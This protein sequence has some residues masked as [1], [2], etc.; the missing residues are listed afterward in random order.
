MRALTVNIRNAIQKSGKSATFIGLRGYTCKHGSVSNRTILGNYSYQ[1]AKDADIASLQA[2]TASELSRVIGYDIAL[3]EKAMA[4]LM[5]SLTA[6]DKERSD[7]QIN[8]FTQ[9]GAG[10][11]KH[12]ETGDLYITGL[13]VNTKYLVQGTYK[14]VK[15]RD[16]TLCKNAIKKHLAFKTDKIRTFILTEGEFRMQKTLL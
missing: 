14:E 10:I 9:L 2:T 11:K 7:A 4:E 12:N 15:S 16:L 5:K 1:N 3:V 8:A 13:S 6:P